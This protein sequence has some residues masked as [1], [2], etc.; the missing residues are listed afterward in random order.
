VSNNARAGAAR[1]PLVGPFIT[2]EIA[3]W[4]PLLEAEPAQQQTK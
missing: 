4:K 3:R 1:A 2:S